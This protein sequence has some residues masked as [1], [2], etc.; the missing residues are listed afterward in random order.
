MKGIKLILILIILLTSMFLTA[1]WDSVEINKREYLFA[2]GID[3]EGDKL[4]FTS[5]IPKI[6]EGSEEE[7]IVNTTENKSFADFYNVSYLHSEKAISD[8]LMQVIVLGE[9]LAK[10]GDTVKKIFDEIQRS[11]QMNRRV[12]ICIA[13][14]R[15]EDIINTEIPANPLV[16]RFLSDMLVKLKRESYQEIY[17]FDEAILHL[18]QR[19]NAMIPVVEIN[20]ESLKIEKAAVMKEYELVGFLETDELESVMLLLDPANANLRNINIEIDGITMAIGAVNVSMTDKINLKNE[21]LT[22]DYYITLYCYIDSFIIGNNSL[23]DSNFL[24]KIKDESIKII[25]ERT[26][27]T[28]DKLKSTYKTDLLRIKEK[29]YKYHKKDYEKIMNKYDEVFEKASINVHYNMEILSVG[30]V[31]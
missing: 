23:E 29:L 27:S 4:K 7:R 16:G 26:T 9:E 11:P 24:N 5:E 12:K 17:T 8:R 13:K 10:D 28:I 3:K 30:L 22:V 1:C 14:G 19:G 31:K 21:K 25:S 2:V 15:A 18:G 6:I 20:E